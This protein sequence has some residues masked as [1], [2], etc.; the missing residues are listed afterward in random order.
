MSDDRDGEKWTYGSEDKETRNF[1]QTRDLMSGASHLALARVEVDKAVIHAAASLADE[2]AGQAMV[3]QA[4]RAAATSK[5]GYTPKRLTKEIER[6]EQRIAETRTDY[7]ENKALLARTPQMVPAAFGNGDDGRPLREIKPRD[8]SLQD[9]LEGTLVFTGGMAA[10]VAA[11][12][13]TRGNF[14]G[15]GLEVF[16]RDPSLPWL[17]AIVA[18]MASLAIKSMVSLFTTAWAKQRHARIVYG[19][20]LVSFV[21]WIGLYAV[22]FEGLSPEIDIY[23]EPNPI[24]GK[25]FSA[26]QLSTEVLAGSSLFL[27]LSQIMARY[28]PQSEREM[29]EWLRAKEREAELLTELDQREEDLAHKSAVLAEI[30]AAT[31]VAE[32][33]ASLAFAHTRARLWPELGGQSADK[34]PS[35]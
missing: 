22:Q 3:K 6:L 11:L 29:P 2:E 20:T 15:S 32:S 25:A 30:E 1:W 14:V 21:G 8:W 16:L 27:R 13:T 4:V 7:K 12:V 24:V 10:L 5:Y 26:L 19:A 35:K 17:L 33:V 34:E 9:Q 18:P 28:Q 31:E 23:A